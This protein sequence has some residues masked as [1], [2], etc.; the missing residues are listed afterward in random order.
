[1]NVYSG[2]TFSSKLWTD[3]DGETLFIP[4]YECI[5]IMISDFQS[6]EFGFG[7]VW[8]DISDADM[9]RIHYFGEE[10]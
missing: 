7:F 5:G 1:M 3:N 8:D 9:R 6:R 10:K 4:K 2:N